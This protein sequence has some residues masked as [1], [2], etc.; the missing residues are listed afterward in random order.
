MRLYCAI[1]GKTP[2]DRVTCPNCLIEN[3]CGYHVYTFFP[4]EPT[5]SR[6]CPKCGPRC[7][8]CQAQTP[9]QHYMD[10][11]VCMSCKH[12]LESTDLLKKEKIKRLSEQIK[13]V[14]TSLLTAAGLILGIYLGFQPNYQ[15]LVF[16][17]TKTEMPVFL[18]VPIWAM[19]GLIIGSLL[20]VALNALIPSE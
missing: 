3:I 20:S 13:T 7:S 16:Q 2:D 11:E 9:L 4:D 15:N 6:G 18:H 14:L 8:M 10:R 12:Y 1:C 17:V 5:S 19:I